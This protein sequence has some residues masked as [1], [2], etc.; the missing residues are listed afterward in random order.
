[1]LPQDEDGREPFADRAE[2]GAALALLLTAY[3]DRPDVLVLALP[4]GGVPVAA[5]VSAAL[6]APLDVVIVRK[7][8]LPRQPELA[9]GALAG[10]GGHVELVLHEPVLRAARVRPAEFVAVHDTELA[11]LQRRERAYRQ[12][13]PALA[14]EGRT[15]L[16]VDDGA[17][18]GSTVRAAVAALRQHDP[19]R[20]VVALPVCPTDT[21][22]ALERVADQ[23]VCAREPAF[24]DG[25]GQ[26]YRDFRAPSDDE[27][28]ALLRAAA[29]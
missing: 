18:T 12:G 23:V 1:M 9:M 27:V 29:P 16:V 5:P 4:R 7:L 20:V 3:R 28:R 21:R 14:V 2:A 10:V 26:E 15:V 11:E 24:F 19:A 13:R 22:R 8:G 6:H 17:A 25:V